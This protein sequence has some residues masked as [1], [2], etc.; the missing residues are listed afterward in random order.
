[1]N[2]TT[3]PSEIGV[4]VE[5]LPE[6][7]DGFTSRFGTS[8]N[9]Y[10][11]LRLSSGG[12]LRHGLGSRRND[13]HLKD[14]ANAIE[15]PSMGVDLLL[16]FGFQDEDDLDRHEVVGVIADRHNQL[17]SSI[18]GKLRGVLRNSP[19]PRLCVATGL[20]SSPQRYERRCPSHRLVFS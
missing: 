3:T 14:F 7:V 13:A 17:R 10:T 8:I 5:C 6:V 18:D 2:F 4:V 16:V 9:K 11:D 12:N 20:F 15:E 1:V 19:E